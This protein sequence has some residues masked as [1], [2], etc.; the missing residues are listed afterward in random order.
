MFVRKKNYKITTIYSKSTDKYLKGAK[1]LIKD[2]FFNI[3]ISLLDIKKLYQ[4][5]VKQLRIE[6]SLFLRRKSDN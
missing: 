2:K 3:D 6:D 1:A 4:I 5:T